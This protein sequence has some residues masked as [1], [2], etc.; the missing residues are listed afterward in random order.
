LT[1]ARLLVVEDAERPFAGRLL[2]VPDRVVGHLLGDDAPDPQVRPLLRE[3]PD[4]PWGEPAPLARALSSG[5]RLVY[6]R[7]PA[8]GSGR[9]LAVG[10]LRAAG[11]DALH[12]DLAALA[13]D[14]DAAELARLVTREVRLRGAGLVA[15]PV[16]TL[17]A[18]L[19]E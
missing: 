9:A 6:L 10:A 17:S 3:M 18:G 12:V 7:E 16:D 8:T 13:A 11:H 2:R 5:V 14:P 4:V 1:A 19:L 15:G